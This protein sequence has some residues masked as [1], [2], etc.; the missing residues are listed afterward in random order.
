MDI[1]RVKRVGTAAAYKGANVLKSKLGKLSTVTKKGRIDLVTEA[2]TESEHVIIETI[3]SA[4]PHHSILAEESGLEGGSSD[5]R[6][7]IDPLDGTTNFAHGLNLFCVSIA[8]TVKSDIMWGIVLSPL[9]EELFIAQS[10]KGAFLN[11]HPIRVSKE[12]SVSDSLL[13]TGFPYETDRRLT[14]I[15]ARFVNCT[16]AAQGVR[17]LGSAALDLCYVACG[18]FAG[19]WEQYLK[20]WDTAAGVLIVKEAGGIITDFSSN[21]YTVDNNQLLATNGKIHTEMLSLLEPEEVV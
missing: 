13:V 15:F 18:R 17:R 2:D 16:K 20:P 12:Q 7:I 6:W 1:D 21:P 5:H 19:Y 11:N 8:Y 3:R 14:P 4:F 10:E 9:T